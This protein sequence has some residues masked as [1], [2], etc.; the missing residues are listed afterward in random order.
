MSINDKKNLL[1][2]NTTSMFH[3]CGSHHELKKLSNKRG[4]GNII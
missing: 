2:Y 1:N 4:A 3:S